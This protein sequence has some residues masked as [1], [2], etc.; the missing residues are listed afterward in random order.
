MKKFNN[1]LERVQSGEYVSESIYASGLMRLVQFLFVDLSD[2]LEL[3]GRRFGIVI[4][5]LDSVYVT[6]K[7]I[8][9]EDDDPTSRKIMYLLK[10]LVIIEFKKLC[11][12][13]VSKADS[14]IVIIKKLLETIEQLKNFQYQKETQ[15]LLKIINRLFDNIRNK[16]KLYELPILLK[17]L[18]EFIGQGAVGK[19][20]LEKFSI[21]EEE[22]KKTKTVLE[23]SG[24]RLKEEYSKVLEVTWK[25][26]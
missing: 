17:Y 6:C 15:T 16:A 11:R 1:I 23:G 3:E 14:V 2:L 10:P 13:H 26:D 24:V 22:G 7:R 18:E 8:N 25:D 9:I 5:Y 20:E 4:S 19:Y 12:K 21:L